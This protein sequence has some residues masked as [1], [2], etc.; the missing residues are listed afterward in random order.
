MR[1]GIC[2][3]GVMLMLDRVDGPVG[4]LARESF[5]D[6]LVITKVLGSKSGVSGKQLTMSGKSWVLPKCSIMELSEAGPGKKEGW[7]VVGWRLCVAVSSSVS[8]C[9]GFAKAMGSIV[10]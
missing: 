3:G 9:A 2:R 8:I 5:V 4:M 7:K 6:D 10:S 1:S